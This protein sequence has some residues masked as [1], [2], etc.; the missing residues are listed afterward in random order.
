M[1]RLGILVASGALAFAASSL[2]ETDLVGERIKVSGPLVE[3]HIEARRVQFKDSS[4][5]RQEAKITGLVASADGQWLVVGPV[6]VEIS[7]STRYEGVVP[8]SSLEGQPISVTGRIL[9]NRRLEATLVET[10]EKLES[11]QYVELSGAV[12]ESARGEDGVRSLTILGVEIRARSVLI[13]SNDLTRNPDDN[14]P[15]EQLTFDLFGRPLTVGGELGTNSRY[16]SNF[17]LDTDAKRTRLEQ[18]LELEFRYPISESVLVFV[19]GQVGYENQVAPR[20]DE[21]TLWL[22]E[23][24]EHWVYFANVGGSGFGFQVGRQLFFEDREWWWDAELD[25]ARVRYDRRAFHAEAAIAKEIAPTELRGG[26]VIDVENRG[27]VRVLGQVSYLWSRALRTDAFFLRASDG[28]DTPVIGALVDERDEDPIDARLT[29]LGVRF[30]G[31]LD[32]GR[33]AG[34][35]Y[36]LDIGRVTGNETVTTF[37]D[38]LDDGTRQATG[39]LDQRV[40]GWAVDGRL[41]FTTPFPASPTLTAGYAY[42]SPGFRQTRLHN[43]NAKFR[44]VDRFRYYGELARPEL[45]NLHLLTLAAGVSVLRSSSIELLYHLYRQATPQREFFGVIDAQTT[46]LSGDLGTEWDLAL[47]IE[48]WEHIEVEIIAGRFVAG[49]AYGPEAGRTAHTLIFKLDLNF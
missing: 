22:V 25:A 34:F 15:L 46:G 5:D 21:G 48:E 29:W 31:R 3:G 27:I 43:N 8:G 10:A 11:P 42:G 2:A 47:G 49:P 18:A 40:D 36:G 39:V 38:G 33:D 4:K 14:R 44:G 16:R 12:T 37:V 13:D 7:S 45:S 24:K 9:A 41:S 26:S 28:S 19:Q 17:A 6:A 23:R 1:R 30:S 32:A 20:S 35:Q